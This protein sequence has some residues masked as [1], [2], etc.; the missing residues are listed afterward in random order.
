MSF[1]G[2]ILAVKPRYDLIFKIIMT[3]T[4]IFSWTLLV[5]TP[6]IIFSCQFEVI[7]LGMI[8][9]AINEGTIQLII[10]YLFTKKLR[11]LNKMY[12]NMNKTDEQHNKKLIK[13]NKILQ[14]MISKLTILTIVIFAVNIIAPL[15]GFIH[16][17][18]TYL[19]CNFLINEICLMLS[20][21]FLDK[22]FK[23]VCCLFLKCKCFKNPT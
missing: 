15:L 22:Q 14:Y 7:M 11:K 20:F 9:G 10:L 23:M 3:F 8:P 5:L 12:G 6:N 13:K 2:S 17:Y 21:G 4:Y 16:A 18:V 1:R 19:A